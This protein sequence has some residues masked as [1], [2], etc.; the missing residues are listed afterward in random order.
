MTWNRQRPTRQIA[1]S[2]RRRGLAGR[3]LAL[4]PSRQRPTLRACACALVALS[5]AV[6]SAFAQDRTALV[7]ANFDYGEHQF[8]PVEAQASAVAEALRR[9]GFRVNLA[10]NVPLKELK[11][12]VE[13][14][15]QSTVTRGTAVFYFA[16]L[17]GQYQTYSTQGVWRN[18]LQGAGTPADPRRPE[19]DSLALPE[20]VQLLAKH[21]TSTTNL[22][23]LDSPGANPFLAEREEHPAGFAPLDGEQLPADVE[24]I[25]SHQPNTA[26]SE[27]S[28]F[29]AA[30]V[31]QLPRGRRSLGKLLAAV[32][33]QVRQKTG[34]KQL[35]T[36]ANN[37]ALQTAAW[38]LAAERD[39]LDSDSVRE[40]E[41]P[42]QQWVNSAG[43]VFCWCPP[44]KFVM[45]NQQL[46]RDGFEDA[47]PVE[48]AVTSGFWMGKYEVTQAEGLRCKQS[49]QSSFP[50]KH[51]PQHAIQQGQVSKILAA[52]ND[53]ERKAGGLPEGWEYALPSEAQWEYACRAATTTRYSYGDDA[54]QL[55]RYANYADKRL[56]ADDGALQFADAR[57][58]DGVGRS[59]AVVGSYLPNPWGLHDMHGNV[60][61][62][63]ADRY[64]PQLVGGA[65]P[66]VDQK[67]KAA[68]PAGIIRGG[69][70]CSVA[71]YCESGFR[72]YEYAG[73]NAKKRDFI[74]FRL[75]LTRK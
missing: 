65:D 53:A 56:L 72:N 62:W 14:F 20:V 43:M 75:V 27:S 35:P 52:L 73:G 46:G 71:K 11:R 59:L 42:G 64:L 63:C 15:A 55:Y 67:N 29:A 68:A 39:F 12:L 21:S 22:V 40:G 70:W 66:L 13:Q 25:L 9:E 23:V 6:A 24:I 17:S 58:D 7:V 44:G 36:G 34:G 45:G 41:H 30:F 32:V 54:S 16:G 33:D 31:E 50:G 60:A 48:V 49:Y 5:L 8:A 2:P 57:F 4:G 51:L 38:K 19:R 61:E 28:P 69:A 37:K 3:P 74:G 18:H 26:H 10:K 47:V 1:W